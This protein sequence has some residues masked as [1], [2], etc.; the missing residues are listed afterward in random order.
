MH[1]DFI[2]Q[3]DAF[4][5]PSEDNRMCKCTFICLVFFRAMTVAKP[6]LFQILNNVFWSY[7]LAKCMYPQSLEK[8]TLEG[9][10]EIKIPKNVRKS[11]VT[12]FLQ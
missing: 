8:W 4:S 1:Q 11:N 10:S 6:S 12:N 3:S 2:P 7:I 5:V 9:S